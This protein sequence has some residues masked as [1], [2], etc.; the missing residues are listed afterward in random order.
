MKNKLP[1]LI[2]NYVTASNSH[3]LKSFLSCFTDTATVLDEGKTLQ[4]QKAIA[5]W[6]TET[7]GK[8]KFTTEPISVEEKKNEM[9]LTAKVTGDFPGSPVTLK[10]RLEID[11]NRIQDLRIT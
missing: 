8:Y 10:Y 3:D 6:F 2:E 7:R 1:K 11:N 5:N 9:L 4:G